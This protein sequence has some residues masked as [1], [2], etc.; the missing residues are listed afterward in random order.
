LAEEV[1]REE[2]EMK[3]AARALKKEEGEQVEEAE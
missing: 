3:E 1:Q 2:E